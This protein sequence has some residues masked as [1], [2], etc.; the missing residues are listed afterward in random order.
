MSLKSKTLTVIGLLVLTSDTMLA[1]GCTGSPSLRNNRAQLSVVTAR[2]DNQKAIGGAM[3]VATS[4]TL[5]AI[6]ANSATTQGFDKGILQ[7]GFTTALSK[8]FGPVHACP[9]TSFSYSTPFEFQTIANQAASLSTKA[10]SFG[11]SIGIPIALESD[12]DVIPN[13]KLSYGP[14]FQRMGIDGRQRLS[15]TQWDT[16]I[17]AGIGLTLRDRFAIIPTVTLPINSEDNATAYAVQIV[18]GLKGRR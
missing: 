18:F 10:L 17:N 4:N 1:Q 14:T 3:Q 15:W 6:E 9:F 8:A 5:F 2:A 7:V 13:A 11:A 16:Y 12:I